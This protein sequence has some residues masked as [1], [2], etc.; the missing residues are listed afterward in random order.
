MITPG[1]RPSAPGFFDARLLCLPTWK[2]YL[3]ED[4]KTD[5]TPPPGTGHPIPNAI[6]LLR[7]GDYLLGVLRDEHED[8]A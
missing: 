2:D 8:K 4:K 5:G 1:R 7:R 6:H 3:E